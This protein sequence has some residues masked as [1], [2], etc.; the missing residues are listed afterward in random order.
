[1]AGLGKEGRSLRGSEDPGA[2]G[3]GGAEVG[4]LGGGLGGREAGA[5]LS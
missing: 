3:G 1:M 5:V 2:G 4:H